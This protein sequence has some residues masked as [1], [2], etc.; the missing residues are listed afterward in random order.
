LT[1]ALIGVALGVLFILA[2]VVLSQLHALG[3]LP[4][5]PFPTSLVAS[6]TAG[7]GEEIIF[8]LFFIPFW[9]WLISHV[10][11]RKR[12]QLPVFWVVAV[13]SALA[14]AMGHLPAMMFLFGFQSVGQ[15][16]PALMAEILLL[17]GTLS[18]F[19]A[20]HFRKAGFLAPVGIHF[21]ADVVW[22]VFWGTV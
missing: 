17:N 22:H 3:P 4:H 20:Y 19:A 12:W 10:I 11:L 13:L 16:P 15:I 18:L 9:V 8:R 5:P 7:I 2:D 1:P 14:F 21:W 6:A